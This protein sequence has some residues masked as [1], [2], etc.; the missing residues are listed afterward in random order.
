LARRQAAW[1]REDLARVDR[2]KTP[3][4]VVLGHRAMYCTDLPLIPECHV[5]AHAIR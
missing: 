4:V 5:E 3:W 2:E 1:L